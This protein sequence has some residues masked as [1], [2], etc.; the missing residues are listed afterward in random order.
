M[1]E[2][3]SL[4]L[5]FVGDAVQT[6]F[7]REALVKR[8]C[9]VSELHTLASKIVCARAQAKRLD[10]IFD[11]LTE[12]E[13]DIATRARNAQHNTV[14]KNC[15]IADYHKATALEAVIG[16]NYLAGNIERVKEIIKC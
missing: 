16:F 9:K 2:Q 12:E 7:V 8:D 1:I 10:E 5:A 13:R 4:V 6:L 11:T 14:P 15:T 3:K